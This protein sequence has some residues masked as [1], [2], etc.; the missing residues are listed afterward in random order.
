VKTTVVFGGDLNVEIAK[1][2]S[3]TFVF[4][5][6]QTALDFIMTIK[7]ET[8]CRRILLNKNSLAPEFFDL[9]SRLAGDVLQKC[10]NYKIKLAVVGDYSGYS[11]AALKAFI[12]ESNRGKDFFFVETEAEALEL[13]GKA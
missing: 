6:A 4:S 10:I 3:D 2:E 11:S 13:L 8:G 5:D 7:Y 9:S 1:V 12:V